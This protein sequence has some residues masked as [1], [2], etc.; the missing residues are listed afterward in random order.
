VSDLREE[1]PK[2]MMWDE[3]LRNIYHYPSQCEFYPL[4]CP[5]CIGENTKGQK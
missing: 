5:A 2:D 4:R 1:M 3:G